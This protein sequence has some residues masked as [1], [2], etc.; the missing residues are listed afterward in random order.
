MDKQPCGS[1]QTA[2][3]THFIFQ[4]SIRS[5]FLP[6]EKSRSSMDGGINLTSTQH[7]G[8]Q[9]IKKTLVPPTQKQQCVLKPIP[10]PSI[11]RCLFTT[12]FAQQKQ[13]KEEEL[14][15]S[16][17]LTFLRLM[18]SSAFPAFH[19]TCPRTKDKLLC[20]N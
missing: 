13:H 20:C 2:R 4:N 7:L 3:L 6:F 16:F 8:R 19:S 1:C 15:E 5:L 9:E 17:Y 10:L 11:W 18:G 14:T 12:L